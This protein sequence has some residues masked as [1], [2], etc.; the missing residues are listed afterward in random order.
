MMKE[1]DKLMKGSVHEEVFFF[2]H[3]SLVLTTE[4]DTITWIKWNNYFHRWLLN[5]NGL[6]DGTPYAGRPVGNITKFM[7]LYNSLNRDI[8][9]SFH[10]H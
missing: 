4:K 7:P 8:F 9:H 5:M 6:R 10:F 2:V 3:N 1:S